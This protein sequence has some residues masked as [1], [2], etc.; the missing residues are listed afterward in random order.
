[1][2]TPLIAF[3]ARH[4]LGSFELALD[5]SAPADQVTVLFGPS[6]AGKSTALQLLAGA[7]KPDQG[8][9]ALDSTVWHDTATRQ[10]VPIEQRGVGWVFQ[11]GRLFPHLNVRQNLQ[12]GAVR[13]RDRRAIATL[14]RVTSVLQLDA[15]L[16]R[17]PSQLSGGERQ[18]VALGRALLAAPRLL[19]LD[20]PTSSLDAARKRDVLT[21][22]ET[23]KHE[24]RVPM[25]YVTHSIAET[26]R[27]ADHVVL[28]DAGACVKQGP[29][30]E[31]FGRSD[32]PLLSDRPDNG[33]VVVATLDTSTATPQ[34]STAIVDGQQLRI[35]RQPAATSDS[36]RLYVFASDVIL[37]TQ[38]P[39][40]LSVRNAL[41][42]TIE[43]ID[44]RADGVALVLL[45]LERQTLLAE[46]TTAAVAEL[47][48]QRGAPVFALIKSVAIDAPGGARS[49]SLE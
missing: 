32:T 30:A 40:H 29:V 23:I 28:V 20:E 14:E 47:S 5:F 24:F 17:W 48:L 11:D 36:I 45:R 42:A 8:R 6:G 1:M 12:F 21:L 22:L 19:L 49:L 35:S 25:V 27:L 10:H 4:R 43:R 31:L 13:R 33:T 44:E 38:K 39:E 18:R 7:L 34:H 37:A 16:E 2:G 3:S 15:L 41:R 26:A 46:L 9:I